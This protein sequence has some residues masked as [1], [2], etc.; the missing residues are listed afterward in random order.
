M[1]QHIRRNSEPSA[2]D[3][4]FSTRALLSDGPAGSREQLRDPDTGE[5][6]VE[7]VPFTAEEIAARVAEEAAVVTAAAAVA[8]ESVARHNGRQR[9]V[10]EVAELRDRGGLESRVSAIE[11]II[12]E[13]K[14]WP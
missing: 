3:G 12:K 6:L 10:R 9:V 2:L 7:D 13:L 14:L 1:T 5:L 4:R 8:A 11:T